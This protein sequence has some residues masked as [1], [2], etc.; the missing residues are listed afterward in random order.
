MDFCIDRYY[1]LMASDFLSDEE[2]VEATAQ[3]ELTEEDG[4]FWFCDLWV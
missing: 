4:Q 2:I 3:Q 1:E